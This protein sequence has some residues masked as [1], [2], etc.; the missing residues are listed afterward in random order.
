MVF[1]LRKSSQILPSLIL[2]YVQVLISKDNCWHRSL[3]EWA[4]CVATAGFLHRNEVPIIIKDF[5][6][7]YLNH[8]LKDVRI[9]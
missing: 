8:I 9:F 5:S 1:I 7:F 2:V 3:Y 4:T 6:K